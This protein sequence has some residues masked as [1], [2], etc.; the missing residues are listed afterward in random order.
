LLLRDWQPEDRPAF[1]AMNADPGVMEFLSAPLRP[2][3][4]DALAERFEAESSR[5]GF[6]PWAVEER[7]SGDFIG[8]IGLHEVPEYLSFAPAV[9]VGW[10]LARRFW[11]RGFAT[12]GASA[13]VALAFG[14]LGIGELVS[15][16]ALLN[17]RSQ[18][19]MERLSMRR[20]PADDFEHPRV[21]E[22]SELRR[23]VLYRL[24]AVDGLARRR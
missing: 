23:H 12:E 15:M 6:C 9:E 3:D 10:R 13:S 19:V 18:R 17:V 4:S 21:P 11:G 2:E 5:R 8:F 1:A 7:E 22:E 20:D 14:D 16:T 24:S